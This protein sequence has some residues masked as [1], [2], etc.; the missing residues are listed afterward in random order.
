[1]NECIDSR[2]KLTVLALA[3]ALTAYQPL[4][5]KHLSNKFIL[6][7]QKT[8]TGIATKRDGVQLRQGINESDASEILRRVSNEEQ[9]KVRYFYIRV[10]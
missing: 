9:D 4:T 1:M 3:F 5:L 8:T 6:S 2:S 7:L 10:A